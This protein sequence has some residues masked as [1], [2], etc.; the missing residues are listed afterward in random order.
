MDDK[1]LTALIGAGSG[2]ISGTLGT[3]F[4]PWVNWGIEQRRH[5]L[6]TRR[7]LT[8]RFRRR[9][10]GM[11]RGPNPSS[12]SLGFLMRDSQGYQQLRGHLDQ[13]LIVRFERLFNTNVDDDAV[14]AI[15]RELFE[16]LRRLDKRWRIL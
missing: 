10:T 9:L 13:E 12:L 2:L 6:G 11:L 3:L 4:A 15:I 1:L 14:Q 16:N 8:T 5:R 7:D